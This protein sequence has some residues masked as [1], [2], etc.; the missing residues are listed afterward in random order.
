MTIFQQ[1]DAALR[2]KGWKYDASRQLFIDR[3]LNVI[4]SYHKLLALVP[5]MTQ[6]E[7]ESYQ[8][9]QYT[10]LCKRRVRPT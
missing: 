10:Q 8:D 1:I 3:E 5:G 9:D 7:L 2:T 4:H 6:D